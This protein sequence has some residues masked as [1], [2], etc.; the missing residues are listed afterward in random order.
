MLV[1]NLDLTPSENGVVKI[2]LDS[3]LQ[4]QNIKNKTAL[5]NDTGEQ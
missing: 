2:T 5:W 1:V 3:P 4:H